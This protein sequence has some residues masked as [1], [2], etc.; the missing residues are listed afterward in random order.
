MTG[1]LKGIQTRIS[2]R[3]RPWSGSVHA[4]GVS[5]TLSPSSASVHGRGV[6]H[7]LPPSSASG[8]TSSK[9]YSHGVLPSQTVRLLQTGLPPSHAH[10]APSSYSTA[11]ALQ[12]TR[13]SKGSDPSTLHPWTESGLHAVDKSPSRGQTSASLPSSS[14]SGA[15]QLQSSSSVYPVPCNRACMQSATIPCMQSALQCMQTK[16]SPPTD[17]MLALPGSESSP[18]STRRQPP[19]AT[20]FSAG[21][22]LGVTRGDNSTRDSHGDEAVDNV[23]N[24]VIRSCKSSYLRMTDRQRRGAPWSHSDTMAL[25]RAK[26]EEVA[27][28]NSSSSRQRCK[29][30]PERWADV[31]KALHESGVRRSY[32]EC[33][34]RWDNLL[35]M[36]RKIADW[37]QQCLAQKNYWLMDRVERRA[38]GMV[39]NVEREVFDSMIEWVSR[40]RPSGAKGA[41]SPVDA[42]GEDPAAAVDR[43]EACNPDA[44]PQSRVDDIP[45]TEK[46]PQEAS[47]Q[48]ILP[49]LLGLDEKKNTDIKHA[50]QELTS[51][52]RESSKQ[53]C[54]TL[55]EVWQ[56]HQA[57]LDKHTRS[58]ERITEVIVV[59]NQRFEHAM[60]HVS[61]SI[62]GLREQVNSRP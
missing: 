38:K 2:E 20:P 45:N 56:S 40:K 16:Q 22:A 15:S 49:P 44:A 19:L 14:S 25:V 61:E 27:L 6:S 31:M 11:V 26:R 18:V 3:E 52:I 7:T 8:L 34:K 10:S 54:S 47:H 35:Q 59:G 58:L 55:H 4:C 43:E 39:F 37:N 1:Y 24:D 32:K 42:G 5:H 23:D 60:M 36:V 17:G 13:S 57:V 46:A 29:T 50:I 51:A 53:L 33:K 30:R 41:D 12:G 28:F 48:P 62:H 21:D 9:L